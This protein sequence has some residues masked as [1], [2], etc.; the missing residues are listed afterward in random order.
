MIQSSVPE[1]PET[2]DGVVGGGVGGLFPV[3]ARVVEEEVGVAQLEME[4]P[5]G[6]SE[7]LNLDSYWSIVVFGLCF[8]QAAFKDKKI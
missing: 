3:E 5:I 8:L 6:L 1:Q 4:T 7:V 2:S